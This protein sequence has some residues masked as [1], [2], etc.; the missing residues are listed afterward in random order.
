MSNTL[1]VFCDDCDFENSVPKDSTAYYCKRCHHQ[2]RGLVHTSRAHSLVYAFTALIFFIPALL[3]PFMSVEMNGIRNSSTIW[4][5][6]KSLSQSGSWMIAFIVFFASI[7]IPVI[8]IL[9]LFYLGLP[10][11]NE[12]NALL[13]TRMYRFVENIGR[14]SMLDI[15]LL[16]ILIAVLKISPWTHVEPEIG[17]VMFGFVVIFSV[18]SSASF[19]PR[20]IWKGF[21]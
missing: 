20:T 4:Q 16:A 14:W 10:T 7:F 2:L 6:V 9:I 19:D 18:A 17:S 21:T 1:I 13:K 5:G 12:K 15:F 11:T 3:F 8:K